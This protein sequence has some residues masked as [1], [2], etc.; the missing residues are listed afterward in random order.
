[1]SKQLIAEI[2]AFE[3]SY[4]NTNIELVDGLYYNQY[5]TLKTIE[6]YSNSKYLGG[7]KDELGREKPFY[8]INKFRVNVATRATDLDIKD[9]QIS[10]DGE[11]F[12]NEAF[13]L[14]KEAYQW[15]KESHFDVF[16]NEFGKTRA[17]YGG[18]LVKKCMETEK[19]KK[20]LELE[21]VG[22]KN[23]ITDQIDIEDGIIIEKHFLLPEELME[24]EEVWNEMDAREIIKQAKKQKSWDG[25]IEVHEVHGYFPETYLDEKGD[26]FKYTRQCHYICMTGKKAVLHSCEETENPYKYLAWDKIV[27]RG[28]GQ[29]IVEDG[30]E[31]QVWTND[32]VIKEH[33]IMDLA[34]KVYLKTNSKKVGNNILNDVDNGHVFELE[35]GGDVNVM[36]LMPNSIPE[37]GNLA[38]RWDAQ[39]ERVSSTF[40]AITGESM[41]SGTPYRQTAILNSESS[42]LF[43]YRREEAGIFIQEIFYDWVI[44]YL[45]NKL[46]S[47]HVLISDYSDEELKKLDEGFKHKKARSAI[48]AKVFKGEVPTEAEYNRLL[49]EEQKKL[50]MTGNTRYVE[51]PKD[52]FK[53]VEYKVSV[54]TTGE[55][56]NKGVILETLNNIL[57]TIGKNPAILQDPTML[58][59]FKRIM[60]TAGVSPISLGISKA[61]L[62]QAPQGLPEGMN[63]M[64]LMSGITPPP[65]A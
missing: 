12:Y 47:K 43:D 2:D 40:N 13:L 38:Q 29:G 30:F 41:P 15:M 58:T 19:G 56:K 8:N 39:F 53:D 22:W 62:Q 17:K 33:R 49:D 50:S 54:V 37:L 51:I 57:L 60:D 46:T 1:M 32:S 28:L 5:N 61:P 59:I 11:N 9:I 36:N 21:V 24:K 64:D 16:L 31:A 25:R 63:P 27:G 26:E 20:K 18:V 10:A 14:G 45:V 4:K 48:F 55:Q 44:P 34:G 7:Q 35:D 6:F 65:N 3:E 42:S 52:Y 23:V